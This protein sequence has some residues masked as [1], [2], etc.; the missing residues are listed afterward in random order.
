MGLELSAEESEA[1]EEHQPGIPNVVSK[2]SNNG[3]STRSGFSVRSRPQPSPQTVKRG[4]KVAGHTLP[5]SHY[6]HTTLEL[7]QT[8]SQLDHNKSHLAAKHA[9]DAETLSSEESE[10]VRIAET[11]IKFEPLEVGVRCDNCGNMLY[12][13]QDILNHNCENTD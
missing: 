2:A 13:E 12:D 4:S 10:G 5:A 6:L 1:F 8:F 7:A 3:S 9:A 11:E